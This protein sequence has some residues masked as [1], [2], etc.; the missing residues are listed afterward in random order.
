MLSTGTMSP[1]PV[2]DKVVN[3]QYMEFTYK[4]YVFSRYVIVVGPESEVSKS[5]RPLM[6]TQDSCS[7]PL[8]LRSP[9]AKKMQPAR[10]E[11]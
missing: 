2:V 11:L 5:T 4:P 8:T 3:A 6:R 9:D 7:M 1:N 10:C